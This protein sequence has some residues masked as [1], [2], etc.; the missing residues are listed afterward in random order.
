MLLVG[1][2]IQELDVTFKK[3]RKIKANRMDENLYHQLQYDRIDKL[4]TKREN[5]SN[6]VLTVCSGLY[7]LAISNLEKVNC[8][9][10]IGVFLFVLII[11]I[12]AIQFIK[13]TLPFIKMHQER[14]E[15]VR[16]KYDKELFDLIKSIPKP[17]HEIQ[18]LKK[19]YSFKRQ[20]IYI[21]LHLIIIGFFAL[22]SIYS[23]FATK[24]NA[25]PLTVK[26]IK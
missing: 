19:Q 16:K 3:Q 12:I 21:L 24:E 23:C 9:I 25:K 1:K 4:E 5:F 8:I 13:N 10:A 6:Y 17:K 11:N 15:A 22:L 18:F 14:A 20:N 26:I 7:L 2:S